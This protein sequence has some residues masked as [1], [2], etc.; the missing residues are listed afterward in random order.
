MFHSLAKYES[1]S[2]H[3]NPKTQFLSSFSFC[4]LEN[5]GTEI[6]VLCPRCQESDRVDLKPSRDL[7]TF[8]AEHRKN[9][10]PMQW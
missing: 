2:P 3:Y 4:R 6:F 5:G 9:C 7:L 10:D 8:L 1:L